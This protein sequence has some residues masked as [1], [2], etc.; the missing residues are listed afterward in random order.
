MFL[1]EAKEC[2]SPLRR[3][4]YCT[5]DAY[6]IQVKDRIVLSGVFDRTIN[7]NVDSLL[8]GVTD[9]SQVQFFVNAINTKTRGVDIVLNA[10]WKIKKSNLFTML[11]ANFTQTRL[12]GDIKAAGNL[13]DDS[14]NTNTLFNTEERTRMEHGQPQD[15]IILSL[16]YS[17]GKMELVIRNTRFG[18]T[19]IAPA[20]ADPK[21]KL[22][23]FI[24]ESFSPKILTDLGVTYSFKK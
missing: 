24:H 7:K 18:K 2:R 19:A 15:K 4:C 12:F 16:I 20:Y 8:S 3:R 5:V 23:S 10:N 22:T 11:G 13:K 9:V 1:R 17:V 6:W 14:L 21:T